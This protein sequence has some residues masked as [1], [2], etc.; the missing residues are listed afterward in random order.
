MKAIIL[1]S[2]IGYFIYRVSQFLLSFFLFNKKSSQ[3][4]KKEVF[5]RKFQSMDIQDAEYEDK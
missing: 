1:L 3:K 2:I 4:E 5:H